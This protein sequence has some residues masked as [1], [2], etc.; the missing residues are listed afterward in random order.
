M[1]RRKM[2][3]DTSCPLRSLGRADQGVVVVKS[4]VSEVKRVGWVAGESVDFV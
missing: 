3:P 2:C 1:V 4:V